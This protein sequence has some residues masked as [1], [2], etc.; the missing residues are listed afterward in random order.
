MGTERTTHPDRRRTERYEPDGD[1]FVLI[2]LP[3]GDERLEPLLNL[4]PQ[5]VAVLLRTQRYDLQ[6]GQFIPRVRFF[7]DGECTL[8]CQA[9]VREVRQVRLENGSVAVKVGLRLELPDDEGSQRSDSDTYDEPQI[10]ADTLLN[11]VKSKTNVRLVQPE[12]NQSVSITRFGKVDLESQTLKVFVDEGQVHPY[13]AGDLMGELYGTRIALHLEV[14][15]QSRGEITLQWPSRLTVWRHRVG[16]RLRRLPRRVE[17]SFEAPFSRERRS[18]EVVD[19]SARGLAFAAEPSDGLMVG[20]LLPEMTLR[21]P[22]GLVRSRGIVRNVRYDKDDRLLVGVELTG[23]PPDGAQ[24]LRSFVDQHLHPRVRRASLRDLRKLWPLYE[25]L[26]LFE[27]NHAA[28]SPLMA[29]VETTR[30]T[31]LTRAHDLAVHL[32]GGHDDGIF[33]NAELVRVYRTSW[34]LQHLGVLPGWALTPDQLAVPLLEAAMRREDFEHLYALLDPTSS[35]LGLSRLRAAQPDP[36]H[37]DWNELAL[38]ADPS[39]QIRRFDLRDVRSAGHGDND[40]LVTQ[41]EQRFSA[42]RRKTLDL[43]PEELELATIGREFHKR[44]LQRRRHVR[45]AISVG[46]PL[47]FSLVET[48]SPGANFQGHLDLIRLVPT[49]TSPSGRREALLTLAR[50]AVQ[51]QLNF[52]RRRSLLLVPIEDADVFYDTEFKLMGSRVEVFAS[53]AGAAQIVNFVNLLT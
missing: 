16:G 1:H 30:Q 17:V 24:A 47:G 8:Q 34:L 26:D 52:A 7:T 15:K 50:D 25:R 2:S 32:V 31:L 41:F 46:G 6:P 36:N 13:T 9:R 12:H 10:I 49:Q 29:T 21:L 53:R 44:G 40:W 18:R 51:T 45:I 28:L 33:G 43:C 14:G 5:G 35:R 27:R 19:L 3:A 4:S 42:L 48:T 39:P 23:Q 11:V 22:G 38:F 20:M 37:L